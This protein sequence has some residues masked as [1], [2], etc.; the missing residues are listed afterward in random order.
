M[1]EMVTNFVEV[2]DWVYNMGAD[3]APVVE[4]FE[5]APD[6][7]VVSFFRRIF[8][9]FWRRITV[10]PLLYFYNPGTI[11]NF[12]GC[13]RRL[14]RNC[15]DSA[16]QVDLEQTVRLNSATRNRGEQKSEHVLASSWYHLP[17]PRHLDTGKH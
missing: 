6:M 14:G 5:L 17:W 3:V 13:V 12:V 1:K 10:N 2:G 4:F 16:Y 7:D 8:L 11:V 15:A 9:Q